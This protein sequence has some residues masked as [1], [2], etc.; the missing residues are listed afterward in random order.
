MSFLLDE[1]LSPV[2]AET[3]RG[4]GLDAFSVHECDRR[5]LSDEAQLELATREQRV[6]V[7]RN[8]DDFIVL[9]VDAFRA[10]TPHAG[11]LIV[12]RSLPNHLPQRIAHALRRWCDEHPDPGTCFIDF[13]A[14]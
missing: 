1:D 8:R 14:G 9:T 3:A 11:V 2:V 13:L 4:L 12:P 5:G 6:L 10:G 7:T